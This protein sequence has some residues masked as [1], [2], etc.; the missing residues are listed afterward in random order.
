[1]HLQHALYLA[2]AKQP[3]CA[4]IEHGTGADVFIAYNLPKEEVFCL[5]TYLKFI[6]TNFFSDYWFNYTS[7]LNRYHVDPYEA[8][9]N[10][11]YALPKSN[12]VFVMSKFSS[13]IKN[14]VSVTA[15]Q[16]EVQIA[17]KFISANCGWMKT[18]QIGK[19][20]IEPEV[21]LTNVFNKKNYYPNLRG[22]N[23]NMFLLQGRTLNFTLRFKA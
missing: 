13:E 21:T 14:I 18:F 17:P 16:Q 23:P 19:Y 12:S 3:I 6:A 15:T 1:M 20:K 2:V 10:T 4:G 7:T 5:E 11:G 9:V 8:G 22:T